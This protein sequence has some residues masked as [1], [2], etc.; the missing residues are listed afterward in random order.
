MSVFEDYPCVGV[1][2]DDPESG[3]CLGCGRPPLEGYG[4][5][6][7]GSPPSPPATLATTVAAEPSVEADAAMQDAPAPLSAPR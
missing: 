5:R 7:S 1:C 4:P 6:Q 2:E 3:Y